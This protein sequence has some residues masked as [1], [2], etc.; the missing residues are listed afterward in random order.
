M[1]EDVFFHC[2]F[3]ECTAV[4]V[5]IHN[6][7]AR[8]SYGR[9]RSTGAKVSFAVNESS[10]INFLRF[11]LPLDLLDSLESSNFPLQRGLPAEHCV[12]LRI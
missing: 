12:I 1:K 8:Q 5:V 3:P 4:V 9:T 7:I 2:F 11:Y 10:Q 6:F